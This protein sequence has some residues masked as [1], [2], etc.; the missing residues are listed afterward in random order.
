[1]GLNIKEVWENANKKNIAIIVAILIVVILL[2][3]GGLEYYHYSVDK[4]EREKARVQYEEFLKEQMRQQRGI[5]K[6]PSEYEV[7]MDYNKAMKSKKPVVVLFYAD[8]CR[9]CVKFMPNFQ[10][11]A[12]LYEKD[13]DF[14]K[15]N[16]EEKKYEKL[17]REM[18]IT[19]FPT[20]FILDPKYDNKVLLSNAYLSSVEA[21]STELDRYLRIRK[22][23]DSKK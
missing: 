19:G 15:V 10:Q 8:W 23:L 22:I 17:V 21:V 5:S 14:A 13:I 3:I 2:V 20:V 16:V 4:V 1:M 6:K 11:L 9:F 12:G 7:G 18:G